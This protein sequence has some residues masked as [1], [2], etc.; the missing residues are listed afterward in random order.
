MK[1]KEIAFTLPLVIVLYEFMFFEG[2]LK[3]RILYLAPLLLT[4]LIIPLELRGLE[5]PAGTVMGEMDNAVR[6]SSDMSRWDYLFTQFRV[7]VTYIRLLFFPV[8]QNLDY[9][10]PVYHSFFDPNVILSFLFLLAI[11]GTGAYLLYRSRVTPSSPQPQ[12]KVTPPPSAPPLKV[13][14]NSRPDGAEGRGSYGL[15]GGEEGLLSRLIAFGIFWFFITLSVESSIIPIK[16]VIFE[17]RLYLPS[18]G[19]FIAVT[20]VLSMAWERVTNISKR[21]AKITLGA[22][23]LIIVIFS[24]A[25]YARNNLWLDEVSFWQDVINE[26]PSKIRGRVNLGYAYSRQGRF[27]QA[28]REFQAALKLDS[29]DYQLYSNLGVAYKGQ[30]RNEEAILEFQKALRLKPDDGLTYYNLGNIYREQGAFE[31]AVKHYQVAAR[32]E[33]DMPVIHNNLGIAYIGVGNLKRGGA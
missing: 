24:C 20:A 17:H 13:R 1:T 18:V 26:S 7:I 29:E 33:P 2:S 28:I 12:G 5:R 32:L 16:D 3:K 22:F 8:N 10:Y 4:I 19:F 23:G 31:E 15:W 25:T 6:A 30:G 9:D 14:A 21:W 11:F 27:D